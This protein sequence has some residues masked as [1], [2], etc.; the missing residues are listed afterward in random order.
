MTEA[1]TREAMIRRTLAGL[2][3]RDG[4]SAVIFTRLYSEGAMREAR[5]SD[6]RHA[7][8]AAVSA[9]DGL[10]VSI[11]DLFDVAGETTLAG[12]RTRAGEPAATHDA[13]VVQR[14]RAAGAIV[15][16]KA[17]MTQFALSCLG[18]NPDF[19]DP[20]SPWRRDEGR[21]AGGS[22]SGSAASVADGYVDAAI[23]TDT[24]GS[25]RVPAAFCDLVGF[26]STVGRV[27]TGGCF[28][29][30]WTLD[31][32]GPIARDVRTC[33]LVDAVLAEGPLLG[34]AVC[35]AIVLG[36]P[37]GFLLETMDGDV[38][39]A[40]DAALSRLG[41]AGV[42]LVPVALPA[43]DDLSEIGRIGGFATS[44][45]WASHRALFERIGDRIDPRVINRFRAAAGMT[46][47][48]HREMLRLRADI[49]ARCKALD[50]CDAILFPTVPIVPPRLADLGD[51]T[52]YANECALLSQR[53][54]RQRAG[55]LRD[56]DTVRRGRWPAGRADIDGARRRR[57]APAGGCRRAGRNDS[58]RRLSATSCCMSVIRNG[59]RYGRRC[60]PLWC[61]V[62][63]CGNGGVRYV[64]AWTLPEGLLGGFADLRFVLS[65]GAGIDQLDLS[66]LPANVPLLRM[67]ES[68]ITAG[69]VEYV[70]MS[71][72]IL[73]RDM[74]HY[75]S[76]QAQARWSPKRRISASARC[77]GV[78]GLGML[79][80][81]ALEK[82]A[83][84]GFD[85]RGW[86]RTA[87]TLEGVRCYAG[88]GERDAFLADLDILICL[89][90]LTPDT[91]GILAAPLF[92]RLKPGAAI[93]NAGRGGHLVTADLLAALDA[94][95]VSAA[96]LDVTDP[97]PL[98]AGHPLWTHPAVIVTPHVASS[99]D[100][101]AAA[102]FVANAVRQ[103]RSGKSLPGRIDRAAG[104]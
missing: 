19:G 27:P 71:V 49:I 79:G 15:L 80:L 47:A 35:G 104:Y 87:K 8:G 44:E 78:M 56:H 17:N 90:P 14:I 64:A 65:I 57:C 16:G 3:A 9:I 18:L 82:L 89:L 10:T 73:H 96:M 36:V 75:L 60:C 32:I 61:R 92:D 41:Q 40:F 81:A 67:A 22:S 20:L 5:A 11:K 24:G 48:D 66:R 69:M 84:F 86:S 93:L 85:L 62:W 68:G 63:R 55:S 46:L 54:D 51:D 43:L 76:E 26:K 45:G 39:R 50:G 88:E 98:P 38:Q 101:V 28:T 70:V 34:P 77:V 102:H 74:P 37:E 42:R 1:E 29:L 21:I 91:H 83:P 72:L 97:E 58:W 23:G 2:A 30:S 52:A 6:A 13:V 103:S 4:R 53:L 100:P 59:A 33:A 99:T 12:A 31:S 94:G 25:I 7:R 95:Q